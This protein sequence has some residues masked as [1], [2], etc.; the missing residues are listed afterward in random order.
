MASLQPWRMLSLNAELLPKSCWVPK[1]VRAWQAMKRF[2][3]FVRLI[4][5]AI[6]GTICVA[7]VFLLPMRLVNY[8]EP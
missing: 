7:D 6:I 5:E 2:L 1:R 8:W 3:L 4:V